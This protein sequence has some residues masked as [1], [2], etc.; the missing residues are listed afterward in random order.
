M[1]FNSPVIIY[2]LIR[3]INT[4]TLSFLK[5]VSI[6]NYLSIIIYLTR[7]YTLGYIDLEE[8]EAKKRKEKYSVY[9]GRERFL[10]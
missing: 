8:E 3:S 1:I 10:Y 4:N 2:I 9:K 5:E 6:E 7:L